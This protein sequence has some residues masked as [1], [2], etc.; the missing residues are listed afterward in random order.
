[1]KNFVVFILAVLLL[2]AA[3]AYSTSIELLPFQSNTSEWAETT[4]PSPCSAVS[5]NSQWFA[6]IARSPGLEG[7]YWK[8]EALVTSVV[9]TTDPANSTIRFDI[10]GDSP[11]AVS[12]DVTPWTAVGAFDVVEALSLPD[13]VYVINAVHNGNMGVVFRTYNDLGELGTY[14]ATLPKLESYA[15]SVVSWPVQ[16]GRRWLYVVVLDGASFY[17]A[18][19]KYDGT[20]VSIEEINGDTFAH[21]HLFKQAVG[22]DVGF[23]VVELKP[24]V[25]GQPGG[26]LY[27]PEVL[28]YGTGVDNSTGA[29]NIFSAFPL[30]F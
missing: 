18:M 9:P 26:Y 20:V 8:T 25:G 19:Y 17:V 16:T 3:P 27:C 7:S 5:V 6:G 23:A 22:T 11:S 2:A 1:M 29:P 14:G 21:G 13:G 15:K 30:S 24:R 12:I 28:P 10:F 4:A